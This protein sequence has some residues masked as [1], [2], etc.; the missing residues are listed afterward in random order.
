MK[1]WLFVLTFVAFVCALP[2]RP[3]VGRDGDAGGTHIGAAAS[4]DLLINEVMAS[5]RTAA[6]D[7]QGHYDDW[8]ELY[9]AGTS[10]VDAAGRY[11]TDNPDN[12][13]KWQIPLGRR[14]ET[15]LAPGG[16]LLI[17]IDGDTGDSG[18]HA[19]FRLNASGDQIALFD[20]DGAT[21]IDTIEFEEQIP[22]VSYGRDPDQ[23]EQW[24]YLALPTP[25]TK[26]LVT[27]LGRV[28]GLTFSHER[29]FY[30]APFAV[31]LTTETAGAAIYYTLDGASPLDPKQGTP[32]GT[33]Y[34]GPIAIS[35]T[36]CLRTVAYKTDY[37][38]TNVVTHTYLFLDDVIEQ[39]TNP[40]TKA[41]ATP[42]G[43]PTSWGSVTGDYQMDPDV[44][45]QDGKDLFGGLYADTIRDDLKAAP[46]ISLVMSVGDWFGNKGIYINESQD[47]TERVASF[48]YFDP[49]AEQTLQVNC[50]IAMQGGV[51]GGGTSLNRWKTFKLSMRPRFKPQLDDGTPTG[52]PS[53]LDFRFFPDS[54]VERC[55]TIV[56]DAVLNHSWL[57]GTDSSQRNT[58]TY[59]QDQYV[60]DLHNVIGGHSPH[61]AYAHVYINGL[62]WGMYYIH[63]RPDNAWAA[64]VFG[65]DES[66]YDA[67]KHGAGGVIN[68]GV[69][70]SAST[71]YSRMLSAAGAVASNPAD[72]ARYQAL[73]DLLDV[74]DYIAYLL[75]N[76]Y[77]GNHD[78][79]AKNWYAT[80]RNTADGK[81]RFHSWDAEH[82]TEGGNDVGES[83]DNIHSRLAGNSEYRMRFADIIHRCFFHNG[84]LSHPAA[85]DLYKARMSQIDRAI[86]GESAR[87]G[88]N[89]RTMPYTRQDWLNTQNAKL[90]NFF[91]NRSNQVLGWLKNA[92]LYPTVGAPEFVIDGTAQHGG[93]ASTGASLSMTAAGG[94]IWYTLDGTD[95]RVPGTPPEPAQAVALIAEDALKQVLV[96]TGPVADAW[97]SDPTFVA[98]SWQIG[99]G[100]VGFERSTGYQSYFTVDV[101]DAMYQKNAT[102]YIRVPFVVTAEMLDG[103][104]SLTL[105][106]R[107]D[108][109]FI[110]YLN[111]AEVQRAGFNGTPAW[112]SAASSSHS[113]SDAVNFEFF[114]LSS[115]VGE[116]RVGANL[117][118][119]HGLNQSTTSSDFLISVE[120][121]GSTGAAGGTAPVGVSAGAVRYAGPIALSGSTHV[122]ARTLGNGVWSAL[123]E[124]VFAVGPVAESLRIS[125]IMYHPPD[126]GNPD[127]PNAEF[128]EL[129]N[130]GTQTIDLNLV[131]FTNGIEYTFPSFGLP[132]GSYCLLVRDI[133]AFETRYGG[134]LPVLG[135]YAGSLANGGE[136]IELVD[137]AGQIIEGFRY[138]DNW[139]DLT[140]GQGFSLAVRD[141]HAATDLDSKA[142][143]RPS[144]SPGG[145]PGMDDSGQIHAIGSV[146]INEL[147]A[148]SSD[149][150]PDWIELYNTTSGAI[151]IGDWYLSDDADSP[152]K[153][154]I[155]AG[156]TLPA[157]G[158]LVFSEDEH[159]GNQNDPGCSV[160]FGLS[161]NGETTHLQ[162]GSG[163]VP[164]GYCERQ[165]FDA[166]EA[167]V[168]LGRWQMGD[169][170][171]DFVALARPTPGAANAV[172]VVGP[173]VI[174]EIMYHPLDNE[175]AEYVELLNISDAP[176]ALYGADAQSPWRFTDDP[177]KPGIELLF[178]SDSPIVL[179]AGECL[180]VA[181][182]AAL[183]R[184][185]Y[186]VPA[187]AKVFAWG[188]GRLTNG[189]ETIQ[190]SRP[191]KVD[192]EG[193]FEWIRVDRVAYSDGSHPQDFV[194]GADPWP[195]GADGTGLSLNRIDTHAHGNDPGNWHAA[196]PSPG[197]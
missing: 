188:L 109:G 178:D 171:Y 62:Y 96:P 95:P 80:H 64:E 84:P 75:A 14:T 50:A 107:Y 12:P 86:V 66:E 118:A 56:L 189:A 47:G 37:L 32:T 144:A 41:Q 79:P 77:A 184:S 161:R 58:A 106:V 100:G 2:V 78:W 124:A 149:A 10:I 53:K 63:E 18:L 114:D 138:M 21:L 116:L 82:T 73:C 28:A 159:F 4:P 141:P 1:S 68:S 87:W 99:F 11:L 31:T 121:T 69:G 169:G 135:Q 174:S 45:G 38:P 185:R 9:N 183:V 70:G 190:L 48:E 182:N 142:A 59:I 139:F 180:I 123:N 44:V 128:V 15:T 194:A 24:R 3:A 148:N 192:E 101:Q 165:E 167:G 163:G 54:P 111:G 42:P 16:F 91:P 134:A 43:Y 117:L 143:W 57:H 181:S 196:T 147:L 155:A 113:D 108:D 136:T 126:T 140:D 5:N 137:A 157:G 98:P 27:Y 13:T 88:D 110:A 150:G 132:A 177:D 130:V 193:R 120:L 39:A 172:P 20:A 146:V 168:S 127:D 176:V 97:K 90:S 83:P 6:K 30:T 158:Y 25:G 93:H 162:S 36:T 153:Y 52:G 19:S 33:L 94:D 145:S 166:S 195:I 154:R 55:N 65:G 22:D 61:G 40:Q 74:D 105:K 67:L 119:I 104:A 81:W 151:D 72:P 122:T 76:W 89:R 173:I 7:A 102:C 197:R 179:A 186:G 51:S 26:N 175:D 92:G 170:E 164:A 60:A 49:A 17:W 125:E 152:T 112:D 29:G 8:V 85:A 103:L 156:T 133:A 34:S 191:A 71:N 160:P 115:H 131:R 187:G 129:T 23:L 46:T 35:T